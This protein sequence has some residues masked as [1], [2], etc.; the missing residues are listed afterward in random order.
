M[1]YSMALSPESLVFLAK[2]SEE[3]TRYGDMFDYM[4]QFISISMNYPA[5]T[6]YSFFLRLLTTQSLRSEIPYSS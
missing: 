2:I 3:A 1:T 5:N 4:K 6:S